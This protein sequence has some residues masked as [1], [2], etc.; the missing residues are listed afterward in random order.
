L[1]TYVGLRVVF[2]GNWLQQHAEEHGVKI[3]RATQ[4]NRLHCTLIYS[5]GQC[6][7]FTADPRAAHLATFVDYAVFPT[8]GGTNALVV[9]LN[10][11]SVV[12]RHVAIMAANPLATWDHPTFQPHVT[13]SYNFTGDVTKIPPY[14]WP[15]VLGHEYVEDL[16]EFT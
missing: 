10:A 12:A 11:P 6:T 8:K 2:G 7:N 1:G 13:L 3:D 4:E 16:K 9:L 5:R 15:I 14:K